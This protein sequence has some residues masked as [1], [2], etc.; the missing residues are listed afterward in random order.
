MASI[1][2]SDVRATL[3]CLGYL[4]QRATFSLRFRNRVPELSRGINP[5]LDGFTG[6][7]SASSGRS[8]ESNRTCVLHRR[9][10]TARRLLGVL[11]GAQAE[12]E[13]DKGE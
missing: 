12:K 11:Q 10:C 8:A 13:G 2:S 1:R 5:Q 4:G 7:P 6:G 3:R 9:G